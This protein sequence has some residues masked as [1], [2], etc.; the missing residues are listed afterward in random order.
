MPNKNNGLFKLSTVFLAMLPALLSGLNNK[1]QA[2]DFFDPSFISSLNGSDPS[3]TPD[4]SIFQ[5]QNAQAPGDYRVDIMFNGRYLDTRTIKFVANNRASSDNREPAL[6]PCLSLKALAEYGV[7]IKAFPELAEDQNGCANFSVIPDTKADFDFT[8]QRLNIS[9]PQAA[10]ST[11]AQGYIP[12]DQFDDGINALLVNY[13]FSGSNDMQANDEYYSLNLQSGLNV[14]P[15]RIRNLSTWNKNNSGAGDWDSAYLYMQR[16]IRSINSNLVMGE[17]S[18][19][20]GIFDSVPFTGIQLATDTTMLPESMRGYAPIIRGIARTNARVIIKQNGYQVYQTYVAPGAFEITDMY[21]SG[22]SGDLYVT[23]EESDGS[24]QE[25]VVPFAT[26]PVMVREDQLEYE[27]TSGKYR[28]Y[29][30]G[31]DETPFTQATATYGVSSSLTLYGGMQAASRYQALSTGLGY[32]LGEL[33]AASADVTQAWSKMKEDEKTSGQS[34]RVRYGKNILE[35]GTNVTIAGYRYST[36]GFHTLSEVLDSYS[37]DGYYT[38]RSLRNRTNLTV[39]QSLGKGLGSLS[40]SGLIEDYWDD[41]RTNKSIS[42]GYNGGFRNVNY[43]LGYS[44]NRY[45]WSGDNSGKDAR[46]DQRITLTVTLPLSN[47]LPGTYTSYQLTNS[48]PGSTDQSVSI[49][50]NALENDSLEW[51]LQQGYSN[52]EYY[53]GDMRATY[54]GA[55]G[56]VNAGYSY[57]RSSERIDYGANGSIVAHADG[58]TLG[59]DIT[60]AAVL[61]KAPGL[62]NVRLTNDNTISTDYRGYAIVP[63]VT[64]YRRTDITLDSSTLGEDMELPET[65][66]SVV[67]TRGAIVRANYAGNIGQRAFVHLKTAS[68]QDVP[69]GAMVLLVGDSKSQPSIVSD[70]GM[71]YMSGLQQTGILNVQWGKSA[72]QQCNAS[73]TLPTREG[74]ASGIS[75]IETVCR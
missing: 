47:W 28:P 5:T 10:L 50:G 61:V 69:Y 53:S 58:I 55:R 23:V 18:S 1:A 4:L 68:G 39:N 15:W 48:N 13:Q 35:T 22:G 70:A 72:A 14:G 49:G 52:R 59:Q 51:S 21:P 43:Y 34:W 37:N 27:I 16:S 31:V 67:P 32:N 57:D 60:D 12:P 56:S 24:K 29:D 17:S 25:F 62:D 19:L 54:N 45:T 38:S 71:V 66:Q 20:N 6:V 46:D 41:K 42:V 11:T 33:G 30:G 3:T 73:F 9:I 64:P 65:T 74:K 36:R 75:Q 26:L 40:V 7:R 44:Y 63:Y 8:A 2:R